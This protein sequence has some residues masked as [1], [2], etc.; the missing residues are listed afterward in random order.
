MNN[1]IYYFFLGL[2]IIAIPLAAILIQ[3]AVKI[4]RYKKTSYY[5]ITHIPYQAMKRNT[6]RLGEY[7]TYIWLQPFEA[8]GAKLLFNLYLP[9]GNNET[10]EI[11]ILMINQKGIFVFESKNYSGWIFGDENQKNWTQTLP[12]GRG[13]SALKEHFPN[14]VWQNKLHIA[15]LKKILEGRNIAIFSLIVFSNRCELKNINLHNNDINVIHRRDIV[16]A[17]NRCVCDIRLTESEISSIYNVLYPYSQT[18]QEEK[19][20]HIN[21]IQHSP[22]D[23]TQKP[24]NPVQNMSNPDP[25]D[26][27]T[28]QAMVCPKC[29]GSLILR[30]AKRGTNAGNQFYGCSNYP[31]CKYIKNN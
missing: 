10:T 13:R 8:E 29:G 25:E 21:A 22:T 17:V 3:H 16:S 6:G 31:T 28:D 4:S 27:H 9:K 19:Q 26:S 7:E 11:D 30:T 5:Q 1:D 14:P 23:N 24:I 15:S 20:K 18:T 12:R 2:F